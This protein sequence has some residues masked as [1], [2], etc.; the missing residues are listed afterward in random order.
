MLSQRR[1]LTLLHASLLQAPEYRC[2]EVGGGMCSRHTWVPQS[3]M[4]K[5]ADYALTEMV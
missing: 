1:K 4:M 5:H 2:E 3:P